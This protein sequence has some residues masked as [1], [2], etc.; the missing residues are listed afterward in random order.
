M[1]RQALHS[2]LEKYLQNKC[3]DE[4]LIVIEKLYGML[5]RD[6]L[7]EIYPNE[8]PT[9]EQKL[10]DRINLETC[11]SDEDMSFE[12]ELKSVKRLPA[13]I[14][15]A[16]AAISILTLF[17]GY[18]FLY[19]H[20]NPQYLKFQSLA[21]MLEKKNN[22]PTPLEIKLE[23]GSIVI[24]QPNS[25]LSYPQ[26]FSPGTREV[27]LSG[28]GYFLISKNPHRPFFVYNKNVITRVV[29]T[30][31]I[32]KANPHTE[33]TQVIVKTGKV[34]VSRNEDQHLHLKHLFD[35]E[36]KVILT[37]NQ[38][39]TYTKDNDDFKTT[40]VA[41]PIPISPA[42]DKKATKSNYIFDEAPLTEVLN[43]LQASY[44]IEI[45]IEDQ[46]LYN[47]TFTGDISKQN[48]YKKLDL[49]CHTIKAHYEISG[50]KIII[51][52]K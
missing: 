27:S 26:H 36:K 18:L 52:T 14:W 20:Q 10:W 12:D 49:L 6:D 5:D 47:N 2:L 42:G 33:E 24:L 22:N 7:E 51:K 17:T 13:I 50:T 29:G 8:L 32:I 1:K 11:I 44:G 48:L 45:I 39:T 25:S 43:Q 19:N 28:E 35:Q 3:S 38:K 34:M 16:A 40:L 30:S 15:F 41:D 31:F 37:P 4:E 21:N 23:D 9:L 46:E